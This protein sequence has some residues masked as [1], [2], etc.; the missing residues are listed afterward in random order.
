VALEKAP[1]YRFG[2]FRLDPSSRRLTRDGEAVPLTARAFDTLVVLVERQG[3][4]VTKDELLR[5]VWQ[6]TFVEENNL[7]QAISALRRALHDD[8]NGN[9]FIE[10]VPRRGYAFVVPVLATIEP[11]L[12]VRPPAPRLVEAPAPALP[13]LAAAREP[14]PKRNGRMLTLALVAA[15]AIAVGTFWLGRPAA[16]T[17]PLAGI[18]SIA[19]LPFRPIV[20][21]PEDEFLGLALAD[22]VITR[23]SR[24]STRAVRPTSAIRGLARQAPDPVAAARALGVDAVLDGQI[25]EAA[26]RVRVTLQLVGAGSDR[27]LW[28]QSFDAPRSNLF[29][30]EDSIADGVARGLAPGPEGVRSPA[31]RRAPSP[32]AYEA[33]LRGRY[34]WNKRTEDAIRRSQALFRQAID[35]DPS[36]APAWAGL[37]D[38]HN[39]VGQAPEAKAAAGKA[40]ELDP[41]LAEA[42][43]ALGNVALFYD[44]DVAAAEGRFDRAIA[45]DGSYATAYQWSAFGRAATGRFDDALARIRKARELDPLSLSIATDVGQILYYAGRYD[46]AERETR[47]ALEIDEH[48][49][50]AHTVLGQILEAKGDT[51]GAAQEIERAGPSPQSVAMGLALEGREAEAR[52]VAE[53]LPR[54]N[55]E[56]FDVFRAELEL[57]LGRR[58]AALDQLEKAYREHNGELVM[59]G[60][61]PRFAALRGEAR[62]QQLLQRLRLPA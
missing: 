52:S 5:A 35:A 4:V 7:N 50:Q 6:D 34:Y 13:A 3:G 61:D 10:T 18:R 58:G 1:S 9:R 29:E 20:L 38:S 23:L 42:H 55:P 53:K 48:F 17:R 22:S 30:L 33:Y 11:D 16:P 19:V 25:Q 46:E 2:P 59:I 60:V 12:P 57:A 26:G 39:L 21:P 37:A 41:D 27:P 51:V 8:G 15:C 40:L 62:F 56:R 32:E 54:T 49:V 28:S 36:F 47:R 45:L 14:A 31:A 24:A 44:F 43:A